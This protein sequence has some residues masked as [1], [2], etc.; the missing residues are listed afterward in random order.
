MSCFPV[1]EYEV[2]PTETYKILRNCSGCGS[3][4]VYHNTNRFRVNANGKQID[5]WLIY[6][7]SKCKHTYNL[8][9]HSRINRSAL[10]KAEY[11][12]LL[13]NDQEI[14]YQYGLDRILFQQNGAEIF[15]EP[16]YVLRNI[17]EGMGGDSIRFRNPYHLRIRYDKLISECLEI[18]RAE[19]KKVLETGV[20]SVNQL[21]DYEVI[22]QY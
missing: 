4:T 18:S 19:A 10:D 12:A 16:S 1:T 15:G 6:Q 13:R 3:K 9:I 17:G 14:V 20:L 22:F 5:I 21:S 11:E 7:C 8:S 2:I